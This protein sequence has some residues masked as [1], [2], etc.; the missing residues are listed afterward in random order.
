[1]SVDLPQVL[2]NFTMLQ[3]FIGFEE[4]DGVYW[5][6]VYEMLFYG[7]VFMLLMFGQQKKPQQNFRALAA[8]H[9][10]GLYCRL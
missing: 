2:A 5:T 4:V 7:A 6:L 8:C 3:R 9:G 1:M 10:C